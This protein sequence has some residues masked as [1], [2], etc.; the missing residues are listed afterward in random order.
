MAVSNL[1]AQ[2]DAAALVD[3][4]RR[5]RDKLRL[6]L[7]IAPVGIWFHDGLGHMEYVNK[8]F[9]D[10]V[11]ITEAQFLAA[12]TFHDVMPAEFAD[13]CIAS[14]KQALAADGVSVTIQRLPFVDGRI[15]DL[16]IYKAV[17]RNEAGEPI[18]LVG[19]SIDITDELAHE[20]EITAWSRVINSLSDGL[21]V[22]NSHGQIERVN[23]ALCKLTG[24][25]A[26]QLCQMPLRDLLRYPRPETL[27]DALE[28]NG[29]WQGDGALQTVS[30]IELEGLLAVVPLAAEQGTVQ[31]LAVTFT[32]LTPQKSAESRF[33]YILTHDVLTGLPNRALFRQTL[34]EHIRQDRAQAP[35]PA[36][37]TIIGLDDFRLINES[38]GHDVGDRILTTIGERC[39]AV[40][41]ADDVLARLSGDEFVILRK[42]DALPEA[43]DQL[44]TD[45]LRTISQPIQI[46]GQTVTLTASAG[47]ALYPDDGKTVETLLRNADTALTQAKLNARGW[48]R[49]YTPDLTTKSRERAELANDLREA[50]Q[51]GEI[52]AWYQPQLDL[53]TRRVVGMEALLRWRR[54]LRGLIPPDVFIPIAEQIGLIDQLG[55]WVL[56][57][58]CQLMRQLAEEGLAVPRIAVNVSHLQMQR[59]HFADE[60]IATLE[61]SQCAPGWLELEVT[62][63]TLMGK[64]ETTI[65]NMSRLRSLGVR[66]AIDDFG[67]GYSS[68]SMLRKLPLDCIKIDRAFVTTAPDDAD[69]DAIVRAIL[70]MAHALRLDTLAEGVETERHADYL[71][72]AGCKMAQGYLYARPMPA[73]ELRRYLA[74]QRGIHS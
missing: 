63:S 25:T 31:Q 49:L 24:L 55:Q 61:A 17:Q 48:L 20:R 13:D 54:P 14:D 39:R 11:G 72:E 10:G 40:L 59:A 62:E 73:D 26:Q 36:L 44:M 70:A 51:R 38:H 74:S 23:P 53:Q 19:V 15:H 33:R 64:P 50:L 71:V 5:H 8:T 43:A 16:R 7:D 45:L 6:L 30:G 66:M 29:H 60:V 1:S 35:S 67:V 47:A 69:A 21:L 27:L 2:A 9:C 42:T 41:T 58:S 52:E 18:G 22:C 3:E 56:S 28:H 46:G 32:D 37:V 57:Q 4:L 34:A 68:L 65:A 12:D